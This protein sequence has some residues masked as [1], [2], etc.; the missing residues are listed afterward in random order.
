MRHF[1]YSIFILFAV[2]VTSV[3]GGCNE[4]AYDEKD[5]GKLATFTRVVMDIVYGAYINKRLPGEIPEESIKMIVIDKNTDFE[6]LR[7]L[8]IYDMKIVSY[9][10]QLGAVVWDPKNGRKLIEDLRCT[11]SPDAIA[12][13]D[14]T[15][16][17]NFTLNWSLCP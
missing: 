12:W 6:E 16:G 14:I 2:L 10:K 8:E 3:T 4:K 9:G 15:Y 5:M 11:K 7:L 17:S 1:G 13:R